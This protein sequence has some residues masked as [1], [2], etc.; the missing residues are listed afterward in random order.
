MSFDVLSGYHDSKL[1]S[2]N[3]KNKLGELL[4]SFHDEN[5][6]ERVIILHDCNIF[7]VNDFNSQNVV[8]RIIIFYGENID[9]EY[10]VSKLLWASSMSDSSSFLKNDKIF[11]IIEKIKK[12]YL[13]LLF[14][15]PSYGAEIVA[16]F[17][18]MDEK[19]HKI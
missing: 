10:V 5:G 15:E 16:L 18:A 19:T 1:N 14:L 13:S 7:R 2:V 8:S 4:L 11:S 9:T 12:R 6:D 3:S 17:S